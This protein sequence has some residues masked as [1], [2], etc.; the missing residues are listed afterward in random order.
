MKFIVII[1]S[2]LCLTYLSGCCNQPKEEP[3]YIILNDYINTNGELCLKYVNA[4]TTLIQRDK[5]KYISRHRTLKKML[6]DIKK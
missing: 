6:N 4:D 3:F 1:F 5:E 2:F